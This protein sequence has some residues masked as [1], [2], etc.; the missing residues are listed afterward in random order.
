MTIPEKVSEKE[1]EVLL[2][3]FQF[4][5]TSL[6]PTK[7]PHFQVIPT[8][9]PWLTQVTFLVKN[10]NVDFYR[11]M[12]FCMACSI[13]VYWFRII[14]WILRPGWEVQNQD[15]SIV[16]DYSVLHACQDCKYPWRVALVIPVTQRKVS[17]WNLSKMILI[18]INH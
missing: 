11:H 17:G 2:K 4:Q 9:L 7:C 3:F 8:F 6:Y 13:N 15:S 12:F 14:G 1:E 16:A 5:R 18:L 10:K